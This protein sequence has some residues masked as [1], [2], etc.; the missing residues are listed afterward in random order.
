MYSSKDRFV[1]LGI[2]LTIIALAFDV[3][4]EAVNFRQWL[5]LDVIIGTKTKFECAITPDT[6]R[7]GETWSIIYKERGQTK[8]WLRMVREMGKDWDQARR[9]QELATRLTDLAQDGVQDLKVR[10]DPNTPSQMVICGVTRS[11]DGSEGNCPLVITLAVGDD[12]RQ[13]RRELLDG[14][15]KG[16][17][18]IYQCAGNTC[19]DSDPLDEAIIPFPLFR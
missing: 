2:I 3:F 5:G 10:K 6:Y 1:I 13:T 4:S 18:G 7:G 8:T 14:L 17:S 16:T 9:C 15:T 12:A 19:Q 11:D